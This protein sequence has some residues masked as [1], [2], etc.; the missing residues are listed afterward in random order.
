MHAEG[1]HRIS[2]SDLSALPA[3]ACKARRDR[4]FLRRYIGSI[5]PSRGWPVCL[6]KGKDIIMVGKV[7]ERV[8]L[9][10]GK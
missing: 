7:S 2:I 3:A 10:E 5:H 6:G 8:L 9:R 4:V 1:E